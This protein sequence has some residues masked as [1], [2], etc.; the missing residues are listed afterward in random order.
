[1][2]DLDLTD[3]K[4]EVQAIAMEIVEEFKQDLAAPMMVSALAMRWMTMP[5]DQKEMVKQ[6]LPKTYAKIMEMIQT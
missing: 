1:M 4:L 5:P 3:I 2:S 6:Q